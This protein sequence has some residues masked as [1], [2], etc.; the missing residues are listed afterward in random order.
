MYVR[1]AFYS[2]P[3]RWC[4]RP[5]L[6]PHGALTTSARVRPQPPLSHI[7]Y[8]GGWTRNNS[9]VDLDDIDPPPNVLP[10]FGVWFFLGH[11]APPMSHHF[12]VQ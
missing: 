10:S 11:I 12:H 6:A 3:P 5:P 1:V 7:R 8:M 9:D 2:R 4:Q